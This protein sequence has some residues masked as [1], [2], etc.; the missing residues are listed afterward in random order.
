GTLCTNLGPTPCSASGFIP[1]VADYENT[2]ATGRCAIIGGYVYRG[3]QA[4]LPYGAYVYGDLCSG[5]IMMF[6]DGTQT[7]LL[8]TALQITSF[9]EDES[10]E[11]Y[12]MGLSGS[13][14][15]ITNPNAISTAT[16][17]FSVPDG[18]VFVTTTAAVRP[19]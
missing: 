7:V 10:G 11:I 1:P 5:E 6:K 12:V 3:T 2:G 16:R 18:G 8:D 9:G 15:R 13:I 19:T 14:A 4:S 17:T